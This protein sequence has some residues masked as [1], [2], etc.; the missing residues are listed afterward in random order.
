[1]TNITTAGRSGPQVQRQEPKVTKDNGIQGQRPLGEVT[2]TGLTPQLH[3][4]AV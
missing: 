3:W 1:M 4:D 2:Q